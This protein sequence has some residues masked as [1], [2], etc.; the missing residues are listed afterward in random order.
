MRKMMTYIFLISYELHYIS[1]RT[2]FKTSMKKV[3]NLVENVHNITKYL[4]SF[5]FINFT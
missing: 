4:L 3:I 1:I 2:K 5:H